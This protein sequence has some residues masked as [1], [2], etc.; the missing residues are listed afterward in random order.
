MPKETLS[1]ILDFCIVPPALNEE[2]Q[3]MFNQRQA[4]RESIVS[5]MC[6]T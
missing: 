5:R 3:Q 4:D 2:A 6:G 1:E